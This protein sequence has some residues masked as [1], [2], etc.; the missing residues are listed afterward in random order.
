MSKQSKNDKACPICKARKTAVLETWVAIDKILFRN[1]K[2]SQ[3][4]SKEKLV[5][6]REIKGSFLL[7]LFEIY[8]ELNYVSKNRY[9]DQNELVENVSNSVLNTLIETKILLKTP[10]IKKS[11]IEEINV[12]LKENKISLKESQTKTILKN[13]FITAIDKWSLQEALQESSFD[14]QKTEKGR[15]LIGAHKGLRNKLINVVI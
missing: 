11:L 6:F 1:K 8:K 5:E 7:N 4:L 15:L 12:N 9:K 2:P 14:I 10:N 3:I 13:L